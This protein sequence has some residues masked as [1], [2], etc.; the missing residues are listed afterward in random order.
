VQLVRRKPSSTPGK[1]LSSVGLA[2]SFV[3]VLTSLQA[4]SSPKY[5]T[6][7][8]VPSCIS[9]HGESFN[10]C[11]S[12]QAEAIQV[13]GRR[14]QLCSERSRTSLSPDDPIR[15]PLYRY[16]A[17]CG[18]LCTQRGLCGARQPTSHRCSCGFLGSVGTVP[19][20]HCFL[21]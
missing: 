3:S 8:S 13:R 20:N 16:R 11:Q 12:N 17:V 7:S 21:A 10:P 1:R 5:L 4:R 6:F 19:A 2:L 15:V 14:I 9:H 18:G